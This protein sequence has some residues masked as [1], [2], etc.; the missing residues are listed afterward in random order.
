MK[1]ALIG[2][3][4]IGLRHLEGV[5][6]LDCEKEIFIVDP[7]CERIANL[8]IIKK[9]KFINFS[10]NYDIVPQKIDF[11]TIATTSSNRLCALESLTRNKINSNYMILEKI[12]SRNKNDFF[13]IQE[14]SKFISKKSF[15]NQW[16]RRFIIKSNLIGE[17]EYIESMH[18]SGKKWG[19]ACNSLH[20]ID[21]FN[22]FLKSKK[23]DNYTINDFLIPYASKRPGFFDIDGNLLIKSKCGSSLTLV[24]S[25]QLPNDDSIAIEIKTN[26]SS[27]NLNL[28]RS[29]IILNGIINKKNKFKKYKTPLLSQNINKIINDIYAERDCFLPQLDQS[30]YHHFILFDILSE[31]KGWD[32]KNFK[33]PVT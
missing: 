5:L 11:C 8:N 9:N 10:N 23:L 28:R 16:F 18:V 24:S 17:N 12:V 21:A 4:N 6:N 2:A 1:I 25:D 26:L 3:G 14:L 32:S 20:F 33:F 31:I 15:V 19:L 7:L 22:Y 27:F 13:I 29:E 30:M